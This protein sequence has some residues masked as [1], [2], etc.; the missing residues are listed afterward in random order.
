[1]RIIIALIR[2]IGPATH[3]KMSMR[4]LRDA[5][6]AAGLDR[7]ATYGQTGNLLVE[8]RKSLSAVQKDLETVLRGFDLGNE[9][10]LRRPDELAAIV[11]ADPFPEAVAAR[12]SDVVI[13]FLERKPG[14]AGLERLGEYRGPERLERVG[15]DLCIDYTAGVAGSKLLPSVVE[16]RL[17]MR[18]TARN[19]NTLRKLVQKAEAFRA[20]RPISSHSA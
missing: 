19:W 18:A 13:C 6:T 20:P 8:T 4:D 14:R 5:C 15:R 11:A 12:P 16:R 1:M 3:L 2:A 7:V 10:F 17:E 9:V